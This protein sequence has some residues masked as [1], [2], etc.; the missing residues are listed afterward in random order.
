MEKWIKNDLLHPLDD[1]EDTHAIQGITGSTALTNLTRFWVEKGGR[2][3]QENFSFF[4][5][6]SYGPGLKT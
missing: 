3:H 2:K 4:P 5:A 6:E 1:D